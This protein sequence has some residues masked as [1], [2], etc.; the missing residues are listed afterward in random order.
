M[1]SLPSFY[2]LL[3]M[4]NLFTI[5]TGVFLIIKENH[6]DNGMI[7]SHINAVIN[8]RGHNRDDADWFGN[9]EVDKKIAC[10]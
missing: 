5:S 7:H 8:V 3:L 4:L 1:L 6:S 10:K 2:D 9:L